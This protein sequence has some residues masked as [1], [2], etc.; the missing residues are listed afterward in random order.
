MLRDKLFKKLYKDPHH[1]YELTETLSVHDDEDREPE[2][3]FLLSGRERA[4]SF[5]VAT[6]FMADAYY[7]HKLFGYVRR[8]QQTNYEIEQYFADKTDFIQWMTDYKSD[9]VAVDKSMIYLAHIEESDNGVKKRILDTK[10]GYAFYL[11]KR[12]GNKSLQYPDVHRLIIEEVLTID[13]YIK[14]EPERVLNLISTVSRSKPGFKTAL[15]SN[16]V[17]P[18][19]PYSVAWGI[20]IAKL[21]PGD[22]QLTKLYL[23]A[24]DENGKELYYLIATHYL[25]DKNALSDQEKNKK[26]N[27]VKTSIK[28]N[29]WEEL[30]LYK[31]IPMR[32]IKQ[33]DVL[34]R[35]IFEYDDIMYLLDIL[36]VP[37]NIMDIYL[38]DDDPSQDKMII[39]YI[40]KKTTDPQKNTRIYTNNINRL[41]T[42]TTKGFRPV[43]TIDK[44]I[45]TLN[46]RGWIVGADNLQMN[47]FYQIFYK[48]KNPLT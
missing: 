25:V 9:H 44:I 4:K 41:S 42:Y 46:N 6:Q 13:N 40:R 10:I 16:T 34:D 3:I 32:Y 48:L 22:I 1:D 5:E 11:S 43:Y 45:D 28:S 14:G 35:A 24:A 17:S 26:R 20:N 30:K 8:E 33:Y 31:T 29:K 19:N 27:R 7:D 37:E 23:N 39:G 18:V 21:K 47:I 38:D 2:I 12:G 15:I 36:E